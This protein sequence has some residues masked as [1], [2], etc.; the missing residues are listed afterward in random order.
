MAEK[1]KSQFEFRADAFR[2]EKTDWQYPKLPSI[3]AL[4]RSS[5]VVFPF[6][7]FI[8]FKVDMFAGH[9]ISEF[10]LKF[11]TIVL[12]LILDEKAIAS[13]PSSGSTLFSPLK[14]E[15]LSQRTLF[16]FGR[17][18]LSKIWGLPVER[19]HAG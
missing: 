15:P 11:W 2:T 3:G 18:A 19:E 5:R 8:S 10:K 9:T 17:P 4:F 14:C 6:Y 16:N 1:K 12:P 7:R 13:L